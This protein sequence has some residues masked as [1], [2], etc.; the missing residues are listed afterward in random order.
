MAT[1]ITIDGRKIKGA[2]R[3][4]R[5]TGG[6]GWRLIPSNGKIRTFKGTLLK[7][8]NSGDMR[9]AIFSVPK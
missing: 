6:R 1:E 3:G 9:T 4:E 5:M 8:V 7:T 2:A